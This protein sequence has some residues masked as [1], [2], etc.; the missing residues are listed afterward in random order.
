M[1][2]SLA[3]LALVFSSLQASVPVPRKA[4]K[5]AA[6][7][8][9]QADD[10]GSSDHESADKT[11]PLVVKKERPGAADTNGKQVTPEDKEHSVKLTSLPPVTI[12]DKQKTFW[13]HVLDWGP[14]G[15]NFLLAIASGLQVWL[16]LRTWREIHRQADTMVAQAEKN[17]KK[18]AADAITTADTLAAIQRQAKS[19]ED[20]VALV[21]VQ[22]D[23]QLAGM[24]QWV[25]IEPIKV[26][27]PKV[28]DAMQETI[29]ITLQF[30]AINN[31]PY[32]LTIEKI[33]TELSYGESE[34][35]TST[36]N[37]NVL[38]PPIRNGKSSGYAFYANV[39][40]AGGLT[41]MNHGAIV[42]VNGNVAFRDSMGNPKPQYFGGLFRCT[43]GE[44]VYL[45]PVG[46]VPATEK[47]TK[48]QVQD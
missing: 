4:V 37:V 48:P 43:R 24:R 8:G 10:K 33:V 19:M 21:K 29:E 6:Q 45:K 18:T 25:D 1:L 47:R 9:D 36:V 32:V 44:F 46:I 5:P 27:Y 17:V 3:I 35:E 12:T 28:A 30:E 31:T 14:W 16:L 7:G 39:T 26:G 20:Q 11:Q 42:T 13:D 15:F 34:W 22:S 2:K 41:W 38:L 23:L 40:V